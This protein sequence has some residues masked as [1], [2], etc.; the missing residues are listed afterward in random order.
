MKTPLRPLYNPPTRG[1]FGRTSGAAPRGGMPHPGVDHP[2][3]QFARRSAAP[4]PQKCRRHTSPTHIAWRDTRESAGGNSDDTP[5]GVSNSV[6]P[7][8]LLRMGECHIPGLITP[9]YN[10]HAAPR[11]PHPAKAP[12]ATA[13]THPRKRRRHV[14]TIARGDNPG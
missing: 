10:L 4:P 2:G 7:P 14:Q 11:L 12:E 9:G 3:L 5:H 6:A 8:A 1:K 13:T